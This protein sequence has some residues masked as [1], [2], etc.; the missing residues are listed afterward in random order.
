MTPRC[1]HCNKSATSRFRAFNG[2]GHLVEAEL[3]EQPSPPCNAQRHFWVCCDDC[4]LAVVYPIDD[5]ELRDFVEFA[6]CRHIVTILRHDLGAT[7]ATL[8]K[9]ARKEAKDA[10]IDPAFLT[11]LQHAYDSTGRQIY[12]VLQDRDPCPKLYRQWA[13]KNK[14]E[15]DLVELFFGWQVFTLMTNKTVA[16]YLRDG[17]LSVHGKL[18]KK[19]FHKLFASS[20]S[21]AGSTVRANLPKK[22]KLKGVWN[23]RRTLRTRPRIQKNVRTRMLAILA[24]E[25]ETISALCRDPLKLTSNSEFRHFFSSWLLQELYPR[26][27]VKIVVGSHLYEV[28]EESVNGAY[29]VLLH[30]LGEHD[31]RLDIT[32]RQEC[33]SVLLGKTQEFLKDYDHRAADELRMH[34][35]AYQLE[36]ALCEWMKFR[37]ERANM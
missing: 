5:D 8:W 6:I 14:E 20:S 21:T 27:H 35:T 10:D 4:R 28:R 33:L 30:N 3:V 25:V 16:K 13:S 18:T 24:G 36:S 37:E 19:Q 1:F 26:M 2:E 32:A 22:D 15:H 31:A 17:K 23:L 9:R 12:S 29:A 7:S 11:V 34:L